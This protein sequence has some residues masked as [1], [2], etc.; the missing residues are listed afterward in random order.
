M[1]VDGYCNQFSFHQPVL[2]QY[3]LAFPTMTY[4]FPYVFQ[5]MLLLKGTQD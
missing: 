3:D 2:L 4:R 1:N 5:V